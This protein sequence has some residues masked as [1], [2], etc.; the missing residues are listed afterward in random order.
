[1][2][3]GIDV[4]HALHLFST[5]DGSQ[6]DFLNEVGDFVRVGPNEDLI[7]IGAVPVALNIL[8]SGYVAATHCDRKGNIAFTDVISPVTAIGLA[9]ALLGAPWQIGAQT[10]T[11]A[12][13]IMIPVRHLRIMIEHDWT[14]GHQFLDHALR[15]LYEMTNETQ[16]LKLRPAAQRLARYLMGL[17]EGVDVVP[18][19]FTL[20]FE[21]RFLAGKIGCTQ[22]NLSRAFALLRLHGVRSAQRGT[23]VIDDIG[24]LR[25][26]AG[27]DPVPEGSHDVPVLSAVGD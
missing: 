14:L 5:L 10:I 13:L 26:Y 25:A 11:T 1:M 27:M 2:R 4:L 8:V 12:R 22:E 16:D 18:P 9:S 20:P 15:E 7:E 19:R 3:P 24:R 23:V 21:K 6:L 17:A